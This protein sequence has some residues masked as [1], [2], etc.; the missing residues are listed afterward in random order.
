[1]AGVIAC[2]T[3]WPISGVP[4]STAGRVVVLKSEH[5]MVLFRSDREI[6]TYRVAIGR[7]GEGPKERQGDHKTPEGNYILDYKNPRSGFH[8]AIHI[9]YP[10]AS[11][12]SRAAREGVAPDGDIMV[13]GIKN[14]FG[15]VGRLHRLVDWTDGCIALTNA[16]TDQFCEL[17]PEGT[18]I[19]IQH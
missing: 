2:Y 3:W 5:T 13:H 19:E 14:G 1:M 4:R 10:N 6:C 8:R 7:G 12:R 18:P 9:S 11:D 15:W 16:E 17:V